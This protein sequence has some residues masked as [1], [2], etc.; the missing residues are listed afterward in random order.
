MV[1]TFRAGKAPYVLRSY[2]RASRDS[3]TEPDYRNYGYHSGRFR[4]E[5]GPYFDGFKV[6]ITENDDP[7]ESGSDF[8]GRRAL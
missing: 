3:A 4:R 7:N 5:T 1:T 2:C 8:Q 6:I